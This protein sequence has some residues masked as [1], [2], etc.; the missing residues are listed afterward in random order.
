MEALSLFD[1][2]AREELAVRGDRFE[3]LRCRTDTF[4]E[5]PVIRLRGRRSAI[6]VGIVQNSH[7]GSR[8]LTMP[9]APGSLL[10]LELGDEVHR[11]GM[12]RVSDVRFIFRE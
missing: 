6:I 5:R 4:Q 11:D 8:E 7:L 9:G 12:P 10:S 1:R 3:Q 2:Y